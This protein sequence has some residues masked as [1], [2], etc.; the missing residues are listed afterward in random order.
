MVL[1]LGSVSPLGLPWALE[2]VWALPW[3]LESL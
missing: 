1:E 2:S 3:P